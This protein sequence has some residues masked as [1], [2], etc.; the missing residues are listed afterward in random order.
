MLVK[1]MLKNFVMILTAIVAAWQLYSFG[2]SDGKEINQS[3]VEF[4]K[5]K[6]EEISK[7]A[8]ESTAQVTSLKLELQK[9][10]E[11][12]KVREH[13]PVDAKA[14]ADVLKG[15]E[16]E[17][18]SA[19]LE[20]GQTKKLFDDGLYVSLVGITYIPS[21][22]SYA[23]TIVAGSPGKKVLRL[24]NAEVGT[25]ASYEGYEIRLVATSTF[26]VGLQVERR[27]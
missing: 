7:V 24:D 4:Y 2:R 1:D 20:A 5:A 18:I 15:N 17:G 12:V 13:T 19:S 23:A 22:P 11:V 9:T 3:I 16:K 25:V 10:S 8:A 6:L 14:L 27:L 21:P 26:S